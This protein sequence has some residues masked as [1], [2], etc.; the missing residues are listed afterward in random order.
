M[1]KHLLL[2]LVLCSAEIPAF[3]VGP[4]ADSSGELF[5]EDGLLSILHNTETILSSPLRWDN[6]EWIE[7]A[8]S[9]AGVVATASLDRTVR[10]HTVQQHPTNFTK[11]FQNFGSVYSFGVLAGFEGYDLLA[12]DSTARAVALD[13]VT[14]SIIAGGIVTPVLKYS[15][16]RYRPNQ[17]EKTFKFKPFGG[18]QSFPSGHATQAFA[19]AT[20]ITYHYDRWWVQALA[21]GTATTVGYSRIQQH[22]HFVS[23]VVGGGL[24]GYFVGRSVIHQ[25]ASR[26]V[27]GFSLSPYEDGRMRGMLATR[28]F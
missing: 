24:I 11:Q 22:A 18:K 17:T 28:S 3:G 13:G 8:V 10:N 2:A 26:V 14:A 12:H 4:S 23:D 15:F 20:V 5:T 21:Y 7:F 16:G 27:A 1:K 19:V 6:G 9:S 25:N